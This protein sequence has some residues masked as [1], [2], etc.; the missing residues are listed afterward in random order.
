MHINTALGDYQPHPRNARVALK[1]IVTREMNPGLSLN[2]VR[3]A[4]GDA[5]A[6]HIHEAST[7]TFYILRGRGVCR[8]GDEEFELAPGICG[9]APSGVLHSL[10][11]TGAEELEAL[12]IF[13]P[14]L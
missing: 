14:P 11:N 7:E 4:P 9:C 13:N 10:C 6:P 5:L 2:L 12:A 8:I 3:V 1:A